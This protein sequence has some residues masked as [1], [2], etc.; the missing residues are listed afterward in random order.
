MGE[1]KVIPMREKYQ[2]TPI[3]EID[4]QKVEELLGICQDMIKDTKGIVQG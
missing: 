3:I 2:Y 1:D 4:K